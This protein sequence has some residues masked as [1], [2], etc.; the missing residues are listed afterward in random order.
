MSETPEKDKAVV[1]IYLTDGT[2][3]SFLIT[4][5]QTPNAVKMMV[6]K[7]LGLNP[8]EFADFGLYIV[9]NDT[10]IKEVKKNPFVLHVK[11]GD[12]S[13][14]KKKLLF[15][16]TDEN[17]VS[18]ESQYLMEVHEQNQLKEQ[19]GMQQKQ[20]VQQGGDVTPRVN[21][22]Y[23]EHVQQGEDVT[24]KVIMPQKYQQMNTPYFNMNMKNTSND[25]SNPGGQEVKKVGFG[26]LIG[27]Q[28][29]NRGGLRDMQEKKKS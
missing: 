13:G 10:Q 19:L 15:K 24:P 18:L 28:E 26:N 22:P 25:F 17:F 8:K 4:E 29:L 21:M 1:K 5:T 23:R 14:S 2:L 20:H 16:K 11:W 9:T 12:K 7:K 6:A 3:K 27:V